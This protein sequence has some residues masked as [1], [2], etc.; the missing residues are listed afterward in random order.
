MPRGNLAQRQM[1]V[2]PSGQPFPFP[3]VT[4]SK[5]WKQPFEAVSLPH[6]SVVWLARTLVLD[7]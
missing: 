3:Q 7:L 4:P 1:T 5:G 2:S 6:I